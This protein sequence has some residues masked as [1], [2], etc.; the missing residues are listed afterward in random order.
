MEKYTETAETLAAIFEDQNIPAQLKDKAEQ[1]LAAWLRD[2]TMYLRPA[3]PTV[4]RQLYPILKKM[5]VEMPELFHQP[6][7]A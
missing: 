5:E 6:E 1:S 2:V 3:H 7:E 4:I